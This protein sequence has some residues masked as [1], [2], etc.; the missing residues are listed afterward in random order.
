MVQPKDQIVTKGHKASLTCK[1]Q[2]DPIP[3]ITWYFQDLIIRNSSRYT[4]SRDG[5]LV[6]DSVT[7]DD[8]G[9]YKCV[10]KNEVGQKSADKNLL[11]VGE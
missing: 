11:V 9:Q 7:D 3:V 1:V 6:I 2:G 8:S 5:V 10:A 4:V